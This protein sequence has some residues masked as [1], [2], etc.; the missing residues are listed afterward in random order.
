LLGEEA[1][2]EAIKLS[3]ITGPDMKHKALFKQ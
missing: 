3:A 1:D 2:F